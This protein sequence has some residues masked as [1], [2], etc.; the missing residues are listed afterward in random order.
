M[1]GL[2]N[3]GTTHHGHMLSTSMQS[4]WKKRI[5]NQKMRDLPDDKAVDSGEYRQ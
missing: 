3:T 4:Q 2:Q 5:C 1:T